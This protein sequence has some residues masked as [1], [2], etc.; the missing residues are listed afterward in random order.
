VDS[1]TEDTEASALYATKVTSTRVEHA[2]TAAE[3]SASSKNSG[4]S[5]VGPADVTG[6]S[7]FARQEESVNRTHGRTRRKAKAAKNVEK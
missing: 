2:Q 7:R 4:P 6:D 3:V 1:N 5:N